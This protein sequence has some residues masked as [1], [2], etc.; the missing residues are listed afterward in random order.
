MA[1]SKEEWKQAFRDNI[2]TEFADIPLSE[3]EIEYSFSDTFLKEMTRLV[4]CQK[5]FSWNMVNTMKKR[6][7]IIAIMILA[8][9]TTA[10]SIKEVR[11]GIIRW[12]ID[13]YEEFNHI[14]F[15]GDTTKEITH[16]YELTVIPEGF[17][18]VQRKECPTSRVIGYENESKNYIEFLQFSTN[19]QEFFT[20]NENGTEYIMLI[21]E[22]EVWIYEHE[23]LISAMWLKNGDYMI[24]TYHGCKNVDDIKS[25]I[26][27]IE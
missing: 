16:P 26:E 15:E 25:M 21:Q 10:C 4:Y 2:S 8:L 13:V 24:L 17:V 1:I 18:E 19:E 23:T 20:D 9:F 22:T 7:A 12:C 6:V 11:E 27:T 5:K 14:F 3:E